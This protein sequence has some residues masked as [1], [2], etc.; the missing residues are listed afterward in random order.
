MPRG[1][2]LHR[3]LFL[4]AIV[5]FASIEYAGETTRGCIKLFT[6]VASI[7]LHTSA[8]KVKWQKFERML[9]EVAS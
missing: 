7:L 9:K 3:L 6:Y 5:F 4:I 1:G 8:L 2:Y